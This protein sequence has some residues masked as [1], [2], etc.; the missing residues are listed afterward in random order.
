M[1]RRRMLMAGYYPPI[2]V[3]I[4]NYTYTVPYGYSSCEY[5]LWVD[6]MG[7]SA[8]AGIYKGE[9]QI[10]Y[11]ASQQEDTRQ[12]SFSVTPGAVVSGIVN[13]NASVTITLVP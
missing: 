6:G 7:D 13:N 9:Q 12:G 8:E 5:T 2:Q 1:S 10:D 11:L 4:S 3:N